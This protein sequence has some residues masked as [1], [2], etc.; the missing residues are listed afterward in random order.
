[1]TEQGGDR[2]GRLASTPRDDAATSIWTGL[3]YAGDRLRPELAGPDPRSLLWKGFGGLS[4]DVFTKM[5]PPPGSRRRAAQCDRR[6]PDHDRR[7]ASPIGAPLGMLAG[8]YLAEY[9][10]NSKLAVV[11]RFINDILLSAPSIV[12]GLFVYETHCRAD[13]PLLGLR[14]R[15]A[16]AVLGAFRSWCAPPRTCSIS[17]RTPCARPRSALGMP[18]SLVIR[19]VAYQAPCAPASSPACCWRSRA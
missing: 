18:R 6:Q 7:S 5:T 2:H 17:C 3:A 11:V 9:G 1:M 8:T 13:G 16:L 10:R 19:H 4:L 12:I 15:V 14:R